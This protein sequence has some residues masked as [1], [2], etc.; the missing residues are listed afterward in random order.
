MFKRNYI[1]RSRPYKYIPYTQ[2]NK[3]EYNNCKQKLHSYFTQGFFYI[4]HAIRIIIKLKQSYIIASLYSRTLF[5]MKQIVICYVVFYIDLL[6]IF[7]RHCFFLY[8]LAKSIDF[9]KQMKRVSS[10]RSLKKR[11]GCQLVK[12]GK[13]ILVINK[14][15]RKFKARQG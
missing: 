12:R 10:L 14:K 4:F 5:Y 1:L 15:N 13:S 6:N 7:L 9:I 11:I 8:I 2:N 3:S